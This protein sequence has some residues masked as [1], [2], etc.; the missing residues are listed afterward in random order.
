M[1]M[2]EPS[3]HDLNSLRIDARVR[4]QPRRN[5]RMILIVSLLVAGAGFTAAKLQSKARKLPVEVVSPRTADQASGVTLLN[6]SGYVTPRRRATVSA[7][8]TGQVE[9]TWAEEGLHVSAGQVLATLNCDQPNAQLLSA[10]ADRDSTAA[11][12]ADLQ[13]QLG[14]AERELKR[15]TALHAAGVNSD[16]ALDTAKTN[17]E[18]LGSKYESIKQQIRAADAKIEVAKRDVAN[19]VVT[20]PFS[21]I[22]VSKDAQ[23][24]E[25]VS[26]ISAGGGF[27]RT[28]I[29]TVVDMSS[30]EVE[31]D[32]NES[33]LARIRPGQEVLAI[34]DAYPEW[35][36]PATVR[37]IIPTADR[38][39][40]T[41]KIRISFNQL[42][43]K[44]LPDMGV[45]VAFLSDA[46]AKLDSR[47][48]RRTWI[49]VSSVAHQDGSDVVFVVREGE[50][51]RRKV[52]L[53]AE[54]NGEVEV[55]TG[56]LDGD[57]LVRDHVE[58]LRDGLAVVVNNPTEN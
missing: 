49:P 20:A 18:S 2:S 58:L 35:P 11:P 10:Q 24:G 23:R 45:K 41:V 38:Q 16:E 19:C 4:R 57:M 51:E 34:L 5:L 1:I 30:L 3:K 44:I 28:G 40:S 29:V 55:I 22:V 9:Q 17:A 14:Y 54:R 50:L 37:T 27:T 52:L 8:V 7:K 26:P 21:G 31:V 42:D 15:S 6:A 48:K 47:G 56:V 25:M 36:I 33:Y 12:L 13:A 53:G 39:K 43:P 32:V 46:A